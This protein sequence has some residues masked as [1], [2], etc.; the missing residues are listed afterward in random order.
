[1][2]TS[3]LAQLSKVGLEYFEH[4]HG[5]ERIVLIHG[6]QASARIWAMV[7]EALPADR[8]TTI[9]INN[10]GA[11]N[12]D[13]PPNES[14]FGVQPFAADAHEL[15]LRLGWDQFTLVG[16]SLGG[17]TVAQ[18]VW[19]KTDERKLGLPTDAS[20]GLSK[21]GWL[22]ALKNSAR[23]CSLKRSVRLKFF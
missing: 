17:A 22:K 8:Y 9:A 5:P 14:D 11:G 4:G 7:Q 13:A 10:R 15:V 18:Q 20:R 12:S 6:F 1:M 16:H 19:P 23:N 2:P 21:L 3:K